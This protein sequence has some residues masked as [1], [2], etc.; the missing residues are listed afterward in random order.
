MD[1]EQLHPMAEIL[2][3]AYLDTLVYSRQFRD[4]YRYPP[5]TASKAHHLRSI[6]QAMVYRDGR[7][8]LETEYLEHGRL[9]FSLSES[10]QRYLV[11]SQSAVA[12]EA[13]KAQGQLFDATKCIKSEV[14]LVI[15]KFHENGLDL[16]IAATQQRE[17]R[18]R[19]QASGPP[20]YVST[21][22]YSTDGS[23]SPFDQGGLD[24]FAELGELG[25]EDGD[26][27]EG[28]A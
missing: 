26:D 22:P 21:W 23:P 8:V 7:F 1:R 5:T 17:D 4:Q 20:S 16:S 9:G 14:V 11:R 19:L 13:N 24:P 18:K 10:E 25:D 15:Y 12:I 2:I 28:K 3:Q 6:A 27:A